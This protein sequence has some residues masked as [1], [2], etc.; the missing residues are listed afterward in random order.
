MYSQNDFLSDL[1]KNNIAR[2]AFCSEAFDFD[3]WMALK[4]IHLFHQ[5][6]V[7]I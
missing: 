6:T 4:L 2:S 1:D 3:W 5:E 7:K